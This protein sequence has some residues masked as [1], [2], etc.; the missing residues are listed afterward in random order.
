VSELQPVDKRIAELEAA[1][2]P[3]ALYARQQGPDWCSNKSVYYGIKRPGA[4]QVKY[5]DYGRA[6]EVMKDKL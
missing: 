5:T 2:R 4:H 6:L 3:F 1:L